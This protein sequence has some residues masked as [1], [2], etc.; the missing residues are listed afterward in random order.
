MIA[1]LRAILGF[2]MLGSAPGAFFAY[3]QHKTVVLVY[4]LIALSM[5]ATLFWV[6][7]KVGNEPR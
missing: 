2:G 3:T 4:L 6:A 5:L 1:Y 7:G